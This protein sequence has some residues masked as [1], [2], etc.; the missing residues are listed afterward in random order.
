M[1]FAV[2]CCLLCAICCCL[3]LSVVRCVMVVVC[4]VLFLNGAVADARCLLSAVVC[5]VLI[6]VVD[7]CRVFLLFV[8][9]VCCLLCVGVCRDCYCVWFAVVV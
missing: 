7:R 2:C 8:S 3:L 5:N 4:C 9:T 1:S 6:G